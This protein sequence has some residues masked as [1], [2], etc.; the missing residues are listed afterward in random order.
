MAPLLLAVAAMQMMMLSHAHYGVFSEGTSHDIIL[1]KFHSCK[2]HWAAGKFENLHDQVFICDDNG[3]RGDVYLDPSGRWYAYGWCLDS[4]EFA[5]ELEAK[6][7]I[8][9][10]VAYWDRPKAPWWKPWKEFADEKR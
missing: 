9:K 4:G 6:Y 5:T 2:A 3:E 1:E 7:S 8:E 10:Q